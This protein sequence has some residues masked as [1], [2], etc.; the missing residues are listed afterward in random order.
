MVNL[1]FRTA[2][3]SV[4]VRGAVPY[5]SSLVVEQLPPKQLVGVR[6]LGAVPRY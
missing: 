6:F 3:I 2:V 5:R 1:R 4:R